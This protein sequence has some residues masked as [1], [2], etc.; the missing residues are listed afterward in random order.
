MKYDQIAESYMNMISESNHPMIMLDGK[1]R[2]MTNSDGQQIHPTLDGIYNFH[3]WFGDSKAVDKLGRPQV[4]YHGTGADFDAFSH[5]FTGGGT[6]QHG[7]G[8]YFTTRTEMANNYAK[9]NVM[10]VYLKVNKPIDRHSE[11]GL[12]KTHITSLIRSA[13]NHI[14][15][16]HNFGDPE[17]EGYNKVLNSAADAYTTASKFHAMSMLHRDFYDADDHESFLKTFKRVTGHD[18][19]IVKP[20]D[21]LTVFHSNQIKSAIGNDGTFDHPTNITE[22]T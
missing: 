19:V 16:L 5:K 4:Y 8:F 3:R 10:P 1:Y 12:T 22:S 2:H 18:G 6:D 7:P 13:P 9:S 21:I 17:Y 14:E 15:S 20:D 11:R